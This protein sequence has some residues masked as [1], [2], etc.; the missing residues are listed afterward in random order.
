M[1]SKYSTD[2]DKKLN[3]ELKKL[4]N[5]A[6]KLILNDYYEYITLNDIQYSILIQITNA[7]SHY[8]VNAYLWNSGLMEKTLNDIENKIKQA[9]KIIF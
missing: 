3:K 7:E 8:D 9:K 4:Q 2:E 1:Q 6:K 5:K